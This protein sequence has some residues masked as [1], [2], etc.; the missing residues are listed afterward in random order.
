MPIMLESARQL[1]E[2]SRMARIMWLSE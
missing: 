2:I 1:R